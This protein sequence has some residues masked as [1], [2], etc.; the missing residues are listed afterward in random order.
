MWFQGFFSLLLPLLLLPLLIIIII[1]FIII[2]ITDQVTN[3][4]L[5]YINIWFYGIFLKL[6]PCIVL[7]ILTALLVKALVEVSQPS[8]A[9]QMEMFWT[10]SEESGFA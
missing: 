6:I 5:H 8:K 2:L 9:P 3:E 7:T 1:V 10:K 4:S